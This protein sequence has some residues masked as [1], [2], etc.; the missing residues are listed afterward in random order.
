M[1][2]EDSSLDELAE[3]SAFSGRSSTVEFLAK[4]L[5]P[6]L[7][8]PAQTVGPDAPPP[9]VPEEAFDDSLITSKASDSLEDRK[10]RLIARMKTTRSAFKISGLLDITDDERKEVIG[11][12]GEY[13]AR[14]KALAE[15]G[16]E[17]PKKDLI[18]LHK[19]LPKEALDELERAIMRIEDRLLVLDEFVPQDKFR[20]RVT[21]EKHAPKLLLRYARLLACRR[22]NVGYRRDRFEHLVNELLTVATSD[23][24]WRLLPRDKARPVLMQLLSG[25]A[26]SSQ[27]GGREAAVAYLRESLERLAAIATHEEFFESGFFLDVY[28]YKIS[29]RDQA[30]S[31]E[32]L[33]LSI[34]LNA[35]IHNRVESWIAGLER[36]HKANQLTQDGPPREYLLSQLR[37]QEEAV[38]SVFGSFRHPKD[39]AQA[40]AQAQAQQANARA[41]AQET[42][43]TKQE[44]RKAPKKKKKEEK[45]ISGAESLQQLAKQQMIR[46][47]V[48]ST[49]I[50]ASFGY[51]LTSTGILSF[52][53]DDNG[54]MIAPAQVHD[55]SPLIEFAFRMDNGKWLRGT[56]K[57]PQWRAL[58]TTQRRGAAE[59]FAKKLAQA[60]IP[61]AELMVYK[62][63][64][65]RIDLGVISYVE[66]ASPK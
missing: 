28:G 43:E 2:G 12:F 47:A 26:P 61:N 17:Q 41:L 34:A 35:E 19:A 59:R 10:A 40:Q 53:A 54:G 18:A 3:L 44:V 27:D 36:L 66:P 1:L 45:Q 25:Q 23:G 37:S 58:D 5:A 20:A 48:L 49:L 38:Q 24:R 62:T 15:G 52:A 30:T 29:M 50:A 6:E 22:F 11:M 46:F 60:G 39:K 8:R 65:I 7:E 64:A 57:D 56:V 13:E 21:K 32:F 31:P 51:V 9:A 4:A 42:K 33:Y 14:L 55:L 63:A 16:P